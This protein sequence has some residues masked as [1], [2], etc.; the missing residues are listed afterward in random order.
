MTDIDKLRALLPNWIEHNVD[1]AAEFRVW[2][3][4]AREFDQAQVV[5]QLASAIEEMEAVNR[6]LRHALDHLGG[7][8]DTPSHD[9]A[10]QD[11]TH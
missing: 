1:H 2:M 10:H 3:E 11:H 4:R 7:A 5:E 6:N 8:L 9:H